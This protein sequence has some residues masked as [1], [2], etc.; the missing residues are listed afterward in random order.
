MIK[1]QNLVLSLFILCH[2][3]YLLSNKFYLNA[4]QKGNVSLVV[5]KGSMHQDTRYENRHHF[6]YYLLPHRQYKLHFLK[7]IYNY[8]YHKNFIM[9]IS[10]HLFVPPGLYIKQEE[11]PAEILSFRISFPSFTSSPSSFLVLVCVML[12]Q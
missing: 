10:Y 3:F 1:N 12:K 6:W 11:S 9:D 4:S 5:L 8:W 2:S 7:V